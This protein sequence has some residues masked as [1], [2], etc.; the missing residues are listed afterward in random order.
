MLCHFIIT[1]CVTLLHSLQGKMVLVSTCPVTAVLQLQEFVALM[2]AQA[3][4]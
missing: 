3:R 2:H 1:P 4:S